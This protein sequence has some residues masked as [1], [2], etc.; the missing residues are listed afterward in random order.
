MQEENKKESPPLPNL[1][2]KDKADKITGEEN[3]K[4]P[5]LPNLKIKDKADKNYG[6]K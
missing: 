5:P 4:I 3:K 1:K 6:R 2:I